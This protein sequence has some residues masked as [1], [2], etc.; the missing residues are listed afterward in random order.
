MPMRHTVVMRSDFGTALTLTLKLG[1]RNKNNKIRFHFN[2]CFKQMTLSSTMRAW[3]IS[4]NASVCDCFCLYFFKRYIL[5]NW[6]ISLKVLLSRKRNKIPPCMQ[7]D[8]FHKSS[9]E[10]FAHTSQDH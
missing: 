4:N 10:K 2:N 9:P 8:I 7:F 3:H 1:K 5:H 6:A